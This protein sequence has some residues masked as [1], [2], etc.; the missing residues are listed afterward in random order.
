[1]NLCYWATKAV[2]SMQQLPAC[3]FPGTNIELTSEP[4]HERHHC[5]SIYWSSSTLHYSR[6]QPQ[7]QGP[8][9]INTP[10]QTSLPSFAIGNLAEFPALLS[11][12][13][14]GPVPTCHGVAGAWRLLG[15]P[16]SMSKLQASCQPVYCHHRRRLLSAHL[17][18]SSAHLHCKW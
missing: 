16:V 10:L 4:L 12:V 14:V 6:S 3:V 11:R 15:Y 9:L 18:S 13:A 8:S 17:L 7:Q 1:M 5:P 2:T